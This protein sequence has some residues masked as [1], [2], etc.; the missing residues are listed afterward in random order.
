MVGTVRF[1]RFTPT[2][3]SSDHWTRTIGKRLTQIILERSLASPMSADNVVAK[4]VHFP[5]Q[6][7]I[8]P[9]KPGHD[10]VF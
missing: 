1:A 10:T 7:Y 4:S 2:T 9:V 8:P 6:R 5:G 3:H